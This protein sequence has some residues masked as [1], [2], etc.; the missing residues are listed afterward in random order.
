[1][2]DVYQKKN[3]ILTSYSR[4]LLIMMSIIINS[5]LMLSVSAIK[6]YDFNGV[7]WYFFC[8]INHPNDI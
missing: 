2:L 1:M 7:D 8:I 4:V 6:N 5:V 3:R